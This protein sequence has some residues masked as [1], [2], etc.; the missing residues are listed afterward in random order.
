MNNVQGTNPM[1]IPTNRNGL[2]DFLSN[3]DM[4]E[5]INP[6]E[7]GSANRLK[8]PIMH[9]NSSV[10]SQGNTFINKVVTAFD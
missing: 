5:I 3:R 4:S 8:S 9:R 6:N 7:I 2:G 10:L 1:N